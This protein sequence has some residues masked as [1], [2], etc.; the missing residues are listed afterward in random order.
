MEWYELYNLLAQELTKFYTA[1]EQNKTNK[2]FQF[3]GEEFFNNCTKNS[4]FFHLFKWAKNIDEKS[5]DPFHIFVSFNN[6]NT[7]LHTKIKRMQFYFDI[8]DYKINVQEHLKDNRFSVPHIPVLKLLTNRTKETQNEVWKFFIGIVNNE[9]N[10]IEKGF[11]NYHNW[12]GIGFK[13]ITEMMFW[14]DS[15]KYISLDKNTEQLLLQYN[16]INHIPRNFNE[17]MDLNRSA[18]K[19]GKNIF[20]MVIKFAYD[21]EVPTNDDDKTQLLSFLKNTYNIENTFTQIKPES[22]TEIDTSNIT[23]PVKFQLLGIKILKNENKRFTKN[24]IENQ[25]YQFNNHFE[26]S[27]QYIKYF[28][29]QDIDFYKIKDTN[30]NISAIVGENGSGKSTLLELAF[31][32]INNV[33]TKL[34]EKEL[35]TTN[36]F[37]LTYIDNIN[38]ELYFFT[39]HLYKIS[40]INNQISIEQYKQIKIKEKY[41]LYEKSS[42]V[43]N[44]FSFDNLYC[45]N[46]INYSLHSLNQNYFGE[47]LF[48]LFKN[49]NDGYQ[50][51]IILEPHRKHGNID[52]NLL[53]SLMKNRL[54]SSILDYS[55]HPL[56][57]IS[58]KSNV[59]SIKLSLDYSKLV[60]ESTNQITKTELSDLAKKLAHVFK[61]DIKD[62][63]EYIETYFNDLK[64]NYA[65]DEG[66]Y[67]HQ[68]NI[69]N[70][71]NDLFE[72]NFKNIP[73]KLLFLL[74][75]NNKLIS[76]TTKYFDYH[77]FKD[78][79]KEKNK[80]ETLLYKIKKDPTHVA[81]KIKQA[82]YNLKYIA[83]LEYQDQ[84][85]FSIEK[86]SN[87]ITNKI[88]TK[89]LILD[90]DLKLNNL[91]PSSIFNLDI[92]L[93]NNESFDSLSSGEKQK[94]F[95]INSIVYHLKNLAS[96]ENGY[97]NINIVLDEIELYFHPEMQKDFI[98]DLLFM[99]ESNNDYISSI[100]SLNFMFITH[101]PFILSDI[102]ETNLLMLDHHANPI[103][104]KPKTLGANIYD[105]LHHSFFM[106]G[107]MGR[108]AEIKIKQ[109]IDIIKLYH[110]LKNQE[111]LLNHTQLIESYK[112]FFQIPEINNLRLNKTK[113]EI[114]NNIKDHQNYLFI[115]IN[116]IGEP[117]LKNK[118]LDDFKS[119]FTS[120]TNDDLKEI[121]NNLK[122][123][124]IDE[125]QTEL[126]KF[127]STDKEEIINQLF[128]ENDDKG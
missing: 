126:S 44:E 97:K 27:K 107:F 43:T 14:I 80:L 39:D 69:G 98:S 13:V 109:I 42:D 118:L 63:L 2:N 17:Y 125:I 38:A 40:I 124:S 76:I 85:S 90:T 88:L 79:Y 86:L 1:F 60:S 4:D 121:V 66:F 77:K 47:W 34:Y 32:I 115:I 37:K 10:I 33:T 78:F 8:L 9:E 21:L 122:T 25:L 102:R 91:I 82:I 23:L 65:L 20:R 56:K 62:L 59:T 46:H 106:N 26:F 36:D 64:S 5:L 114:L 28:I 45:T 15:S 71:I 58:K 53:Q 30:I 18:Q 128:K 111:T 113:Q 3:A 49:K 101:S 50:H 73:L 127:S 93:E 96:Q 103:D 68:K 89:N 54:L 12:Y 7:T 35:L 87:K 48:T 72:E 110:N 61:I 19:F 29:S 116:S 16:V 52:I 22:L 105:L 75:I 31:M 41:V 92:I 120:I 11:I 99:L 84:K 83:E 57:Q 24:L 100:S 74:Y 108:F 112:T 117:I 67:L 104:K 51:P 6:N 70:N 55:A 95:V 119:T 81:F 94:I 123:K